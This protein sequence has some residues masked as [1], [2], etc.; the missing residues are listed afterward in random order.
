MLTVNKPT[1]RKQNG[2]FA[3]KPQQV[4]KNANITFGAPNQPVNVY[5]CVCVVCVFKSS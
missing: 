4:L 1:K 5:V 2:K 3:S